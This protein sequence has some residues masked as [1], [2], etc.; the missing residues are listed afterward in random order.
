MVL[1]YKVGD[2]W[3]SRCLRVEFDD[4]FP[5]RGERE[6]NGEL[7]KNTGAGGWTLKGQGAELSLGAMRK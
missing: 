1:W 5:K 3:L 4:S 6:F 7:D 2:R